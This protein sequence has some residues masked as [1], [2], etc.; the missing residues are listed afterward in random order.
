MLLIVLQPG[1]SILFFF[2]NFTMS[3]FANRL[4][5]LAFLLSSSLPGRSGGAP[6]LFSSFSPG[7]QWLLLLP[8]NLL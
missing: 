7:L 4:L 1:Q 3:V 5:F 6:T 2:F 8:G